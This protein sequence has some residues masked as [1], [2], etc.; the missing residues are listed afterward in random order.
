MP[1]LVF[2]ADSSRPSQSWTRAAIRQLCRRLRKWQKPSFSSCPALA[3]SFYRPAARPNTITSC[4]QAFIDVLQS[5]FVPRERTC[6]V[7]VERPSVGLSR[8]ICRLAME[9]CKRHP[10]WG[11]LVIQARIRSAARRIPFLHMMASLIL[12]QFPGKDDRELNIHVVLVRSHQYMKKSE[13]QA[14]FMDLWTITT[15]ISLN[16]WNEWLW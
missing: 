10:G 16:H 7:A 1:P 15:Q 13:G 8:H 3:R 12:W 9:K 11:R 4:G 6:R 14:L 2:G 5:K